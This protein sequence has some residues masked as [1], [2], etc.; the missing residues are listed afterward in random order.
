MK[1]L[2][3]HAAQLGV[4]VHMAHLPEPYRGFYDSARRIVVYGFD[5]T[6]VEKVSVLA[7]ELGHAFYDHQCYGDS[8]AEEAADRYAARLLIDP[9]EY[10]SAESI[11]ASPDAI[12]DELGVLPK[13]VLAYQ[14][15]ALTVLR[16]VTYARGLG[17]RMVGFATPGA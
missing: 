15:S 7:H 5:L 14:Q 3:A 13:L 12:A 9:L 8:A 10:A 16:G 2:L 17:G 6:P 11:D 4:S 1:E